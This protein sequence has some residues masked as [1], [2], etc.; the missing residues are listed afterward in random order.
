[1][2]GKMLLPPAIRLKY[3]MSERQRRNCCMEFIEYERTRVVNIPAETPGS[4]L[5]ENL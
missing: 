5:V 1:M 2:S 3:S 4:S